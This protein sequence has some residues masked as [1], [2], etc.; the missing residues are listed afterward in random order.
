MHQP[1]LDL[2]TAEQTRLLDRYAIEQAGIAGYELMKKAGASAF[3]AIM[4]R[5]PDTKK[6]II[7]CGTGNNGGD[8]YVI[9]RLAKKREL[10]VQVYQ[11]GDLQK[12][13]GDALIARLDMEAEGIAIEQYKAQ[14]ITATSSDVIVDA[15]LGTGLERDVKNEWQQVICDINTTHLLNKTRVAAVD[16]CSGLNADTGSVLGAAIT[17]DISITFIG[18]KQGLYSG[19]GPEKSGD[20]VFDSLSVPDDIYDKVKP[21]SYCLPAKLSAEVLKPRVKNSH[22]NSFGNL[23][24]IGGAPG[25]SGAI[26]LS[27]TA[28][29]RTGAGL[30]TV[31]THP[32]HAGAINLPQPEIMS[33]GV[34]NP[35]QLQTFFA[36]SDIIIVGPG[37]GTDQWGKNLLAAAVNA[38]KPLIIDAD[39]LNSL[40]HDK[41]FNQPVV[42]TPHPGEAAR[43][44]DCSVQDVQSDRFTTAKQISE[45]F[46]AVC[47]L[48]GS[49]TIIHSSDG[50]FVC[51]AGNP[52]MATAGMGDVLSGIL[53]CLVAQGL[54]ANRTMTQ[55][56]NDAV[57][58]HALAGDSAAH[59][60]GE[61]GL[62][63]SDLYSHIRRLINAR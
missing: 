26:V 62:V 24:F 35:D 1:Y 45:K 49:G 31:I 39:G 37:L 28:A 63:A 2:Y 53:G 13:S 17:A 21:N 30:V 40:P 42:L 11:L 15:L 59:E 10:S 29:L 18:R 60:A 48:K 33:R 3:H 5:W 6:L 57:L 38:D 58:L 34:D 4:S 46:N 7:F 41:V 51:P 16:I 23:L 12:Q 55:S 19:Y 25:M 20:V 22:K 43:L 14:H 50:S 9:A 52:G 27:A 32:D 8:G 47:V 54:K 61:K 44:L 36:K 56:V